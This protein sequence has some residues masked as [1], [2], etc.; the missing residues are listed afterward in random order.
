M[1]VDIHAHF[2]PPEWINEL[3]RNG[4]TYGCRIHQDESGR[5]WLRLGEGKPKELTPALANL[6]SRFQAMAE[7]GVDR[8]VLSPVMN[9]VGYE[10]DERYGQ[11]L[12]RL[13]N[14]TNAES[15]KK[16]DGR[17]IPVANI[18]MQSSRAAVEEL[19]YAVK[20]L[21]IRMIEIGTHVN[22]LNLDE[23]VFRPFFERAADLGVLVQI[24]PHKIAAPDRLRRY[25]LSNLIGNPV[26]T[27]IAAASLIFGGI[28][29][30]YPSLNI[31]LVH[32]GGALP[33]LLGRLSHGYFAFAESH[34][35]PKPPETYFRR[36]YFDTLAHDARVLA[37]LNSLAGA[38]RLMLGTDYP[39]AAGD[40]NPLEKLRNAGLENEQNILGRNAVRLLG[41]TEK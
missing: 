4:A 16:Y 17:F 2:T 10:L 12:C 26:D 39:Y 37:F 30:R 31:C 6:S 7:L 21:R 1:I 9:T 32:G 41:L 24:H 27:A 14:E 20:N 36:F 38:E 19:D 13:F 11:A 3:Q 18:P 40:K 23:E 28:L 34:V 22:G 25:N 35:T 15:A 5:L 8:Q 33:Y 29:D